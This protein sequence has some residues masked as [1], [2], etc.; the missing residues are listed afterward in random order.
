MPIYYA[1]KPQRTEKSDFERLA[2]EI[3]KGVQAYRE[4]KATQKSKKQTTS[5][6]A[7]SP[8]VEQL[9]EI[10]SGRRKYDRSVRPM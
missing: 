8:E 6:R 3:I 4:K 5:S 1:P 9:P 2:E 10:G 7:T